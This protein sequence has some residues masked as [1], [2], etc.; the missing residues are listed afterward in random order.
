MNADVVILPTY[1]E[2]ANI[3]QSIRDVYRYV[4]GVTI[5][6]VDDNSPDG[7]ADV[8][9]G[10]TAEFP[11]LIIYVR[12]KKEGLGAAYKDILGQLQTNTAVRK[13][14]HMDADGSHDPA[15][16]PQMFECLEREELVSGSRY[17]RG[18]GVDGWAWHRVLISRVGN[19]YLRTLAPIPVRDVSGGFLAMR[20]TLLEKIPFHILSGDSYGYMIEFKYYCVRALKIHIHEIPIHFKPRREGESKMTLKILF[21]EGLL[22]FKIF[23]H[24][25]RY[26]GASIVPNDR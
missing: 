19:W 21:E 23:L 13:I 11:T 6:V 22:P 16:L 24:R 25:K 18:G 20:R 10:L 2:A 9:R 7:T 3:E 26:A 8:V 15:Y 17:V 4:P 1:N 12:A 14:V 5:V